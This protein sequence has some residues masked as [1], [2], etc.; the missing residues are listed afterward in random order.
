MHVG[1]A[2]NDSERVTR[3]CRREVFRSYYIFH[4]YANAVSRPQRD[5]PF[6]R[7]CQV[8]TIRF[9]LVPHK[10][11]ASEIDSRWL[12]AGDIDRD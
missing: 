12:Y 5:L 10:F 1:C 2:P 4:R 3:E 8:Y 9:P 11:I 7:V 6:I